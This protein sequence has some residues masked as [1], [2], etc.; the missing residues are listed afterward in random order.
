MT[1]PTLSPATQASV[2]G[3]VRAKADLEQWT[4]NLEQAL[5]DDVS[6]NPPRLTQDEAA[7]VAKT[8][9]VDAPHEPKA[10]KPE[11]EPEKEPEVEKESAEVEAYDDAPTSGARHAKSRHD[12]PKR[13]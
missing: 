3:L 12:K 9:G 4:H 1:E 6:A 11:P 2:Q 7:E 13:G 8:Y 5:A 10:A